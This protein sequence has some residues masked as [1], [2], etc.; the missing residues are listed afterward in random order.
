MGNHYT[1]QPQDL[2]GPAQ[3]RCPKRLAV[4]RVEWGRTARMDLTWLKRT[5]RKYWL[6][7][8]SFPLVYWIH[9]WGSIWVCFIVAAGLL[10]RKIIQN[11]FL[12][13]TKGVYPFVEPCPNIFE[14]EPNTPVLVAGCRYF[15]RRCMLESRVRVNKLPCSHFDERY[16]ISSSTKCDTIWHHLGDCNGLTTLL[17]FH[18][19][20]SQETWRELILVL[21]FWC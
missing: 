6:L 11:P 8:K 15:L 7:Y 20:Q 14:Y 12:G 10:R 13:F 18:R 21:L 9:F 1:K 5:D 17:C 19:M 4:Q 3:I 16:P 2:P